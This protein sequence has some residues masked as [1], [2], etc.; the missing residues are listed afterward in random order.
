MAL[1]LEDGSLRTQ[2]VAGWG[3]V[4]PGVSP[5]LGEEA[6]PPALIPTSLGPLLFPQGLVVQLFF[7]FPRNIPVVLPANPPF[8]SEANQPCFVLL[9]NQKNLLTSREILAVD[10]VLLSFVEVL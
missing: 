9:R 2:E 10:R 8:S 1:W 7:H 6:A 5:L 3:N 4:G